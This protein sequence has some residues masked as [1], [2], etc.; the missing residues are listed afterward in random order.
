M[1]TQ[2]H[3]AA[4]PQKLSSGFMGAILLHIAVALAIVAATFLPAFHKPNWGE[5]S[6]SVGSIQASIVNAIPLPP[7]APS[8]EHSVLTSE[9]VSPAPE[10]KTKEAT[11]PPPKPTDLLIKKPEAKPTPVKP[12]PREAEATKHPQPTPVTPKATNGDTATQLPQS[13][14]QTANGTATVTVQNRVFG[15]RYAYYLRGLSN[16]INRNYSQ[17]YPDPRASQDRYV[18]I[19]FDVERDGSVANL[20]ITHPSGSPTLDNAGRHAILEVDSFGRLPEGDHISIEYKF[21]Y[22]HP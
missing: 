18:T 13:I 9:N 12:A 14:T 22:H 4:A 10:E 1:S 6:S 11:A 15:D 8:V 3:P 19:L 2:A 5:Q 7:K 16:T 20:R 17:Q 21:D